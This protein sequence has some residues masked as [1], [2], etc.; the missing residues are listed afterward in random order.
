MN[1]TE[2]AHPGRSSSVDKALTVLEILTAA[3]RPLR[4]SEIARRARFA[5]STTHRLLAALG[6]HQMVAGA[7]GSYMLG[8]R[9]LDQALPADATET[10]LLRVT[11]MPFLIDLYNLT[12]GAVYLGILRDGRV[13][14]LASLFGHKTIATPSRNRDWAPAHCTA[15]GKLLLSGRPPEDQQS[16]RT[17]TPSRFS[18]QLLAVRRT[19]IAHN[20]GEYIPGVACVAIGIADSPATPHAAIAVGDHIDRLDPIRTI[21]H[22]RNISFACSVAVQRAPARDATSGN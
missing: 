13:N 9:L 5:K 8:D 11:A 15:I 19:G 16:D 12:H 21:R 17:D 3:E 6:S 14:Y 1:E 4:L 7:V 10:R 20:R 2:Y 22:L 18:D